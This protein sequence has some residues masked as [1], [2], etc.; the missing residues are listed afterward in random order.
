MHWCHSWWFPT[1]TRA[2]CGWWSADGGW[3][4]VFPSSWGFFCPP[5][6]KGGW[7]CVGIVCTPIYSWLSTFPSSCPHTPQTPLWLWAIPPLDMPPC[8]GNISTRICHVGMNRH[9]NNPQWTQSHPTYTWKKDSWGIV[10]WCRIE[11]N[12]YMSRGTPPQMPQSVG[13]RFINWVR[14]VPSWRMVAGVVFVHDGV[15]GLIDRFSSSLIY[16]D[17]PSRDDG[18]P[19]STSWRCRV[20]ESCFWGGNGG[21]GHGGGHN[22]HAYIDVEYS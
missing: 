10:F 21:N 1:C 15:D 12:I 11:H 16:V 3:V 17:Y 14:S 20:D 9:H 7:C 19:P 2:G 22:S 18:Y 4:I 5:H 8:I 6:H 13:S